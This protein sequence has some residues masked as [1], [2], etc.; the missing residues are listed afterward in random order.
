MDYRNRK[1]A[2]GA[3]HPGVSGGGS[4]ADR[5]GSE[6]TREDSQDDAG[7]RQRSRAQQVESASTHMQIT[8]VMSRDRPALFCRLPIRMRRSNFPNT[9]ISDVF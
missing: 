4:G 6:G 8:R 7:K 1:F 5:N 3:H 9:V 2:G